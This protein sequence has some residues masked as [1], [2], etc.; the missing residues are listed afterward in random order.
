MEPTTNLRNTEKSRILVMTVG[1]GVGPDKEKKVRS[2]AHGLLQSIKHYNPNQ[3]VYFGSEESK[4]TMDMVETIAN[5]MQVCL[6]LVKDRIILENIDDFDKCMK[7]MQDE[8]ENLKKEMS[9]PEIIMDYTSGTKTMTAAIVV[10]S[11]L[12]HLKLSLV[13]GKRSLDSVVQSGTE[14]IQTQNPYRAYDKLLIGKLIESINTCRFNT[15]RQYLIQ[16]VDFPPEK[17]DYYEHI[18]GGYDAWDKFDHNRA[19]DELRKIT[20]NQDP[21]G[22]FKAN[23]EFL[24]KLLNIE[25]PTSKSEFYIAD[26]VNNARRRVEEGKYDDAV[27]RLYRTIEL[28][29]QYLLKRLYNI[30]TDKVDLNILSEKGVPQ[31]YINDLKALQ[32]EQGRIKIGL[33]R[34]YEILEKLGNGIGKK[35]MGDSRLQDLLRKRNES[36]LAHGTKPVTMADCEALESATEEYVKAVFSGANEHINNSCFVKMRS[37]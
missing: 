16:L 12:Y 4:V 29:E 17:K 32:D 22:L 19:F 5:E 37:E 18:I 28:I 33:K 8:I 6:P 9:N 3:I 30:Q 11:I 31:E 23:K 25:D 10:L 2:L 1:T 15:A 26:L 20:K 14:N 36:I 7:Q 24:G 27:A 13:G 35:Y 34:G 21:G